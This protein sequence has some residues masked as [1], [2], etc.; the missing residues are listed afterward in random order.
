MPIQFCGHCIDPFSCTHLPL[1][2]LVLLPSPLEIRACACRPGPPF[3]MAKQGYFVHLPLLLFL[4]AAGL[5]AW[6]LLIGVI[7]V[8]KQKTNTQT[9][10]ASAS[11]HH[12]SLDANFILSRFM[13][14]EA[15]VDPI[16]SIKSARVSA[17]VGERASCVF[18]S[19]EPKQNAAIGTLRAGD[20]GSTSWFS[21]LARSWR[22]GPDAVQKLHSPSQSLLANNVRLPPHSKGTRTQA[23]APLTSAVHAV[24]AFSALDCDASVADNA[25]LIQIYHSKME[26][27]IS[28]ISATFFL[29]PGCAIDAVGF[30][31]STGGNVDGPTVPAAVRGLSSEVALAIRR[32]AFSLA[33]LSLPT[34]PSSPVPV[35]GWTVQS[36]SLSVMLYIIAAFGWGCYALRHILVFYRNRCCIR[37]RSD[38]PSCC[39]S[40][41]DVEFSAAGGRQWQWQAVRGQ[42]QQHSLLQLVNLPSRGAMEGGRC[43]RMFAVPARRFVVSTPQQSHA[44]YIEFDL[45]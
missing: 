18:L 43:R 5:L 26:G 23:R 24:A 39:L 15:K 1:C 16:V 34:H 25:A 2:L 27:V 7:Q 38:K 29:P 22:I 14:D 37:S 42:L 19:R 17:A 11:S 20:G 6:V 8:A 9:R 36:G 33:G 31:Y 12:V 32:F 21:A 45:A 13:Y 30:P 35:T 41:A 4:L 44:A 3:A 40:D 28:P 10:A